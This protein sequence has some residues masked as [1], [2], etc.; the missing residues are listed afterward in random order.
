MS[1]ENRIEVFIV[2]A[3]FYTTEFSLTAVLYTATCVINILI[4]IAIVNSTEYKGY[5]V[6]RSRNK[7]TGQGI[8]GQECETKKRS[9]QAFSRPFIAP[10]KKLFFSLSVRAFITMSLPQG[11]MSKRPCPGSE[12]SDLISSALLLNQAE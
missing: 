12:Q 7:K 2:I 9:A 11:W 3:H 8:S 4:H 5:G 6:K 10:E 1:L